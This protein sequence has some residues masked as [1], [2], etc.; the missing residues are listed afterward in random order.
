MIVFLGL[1]S[2][3][4]HVIWVDFRT[5]GKMVEGEEETLLGT[6]WTGQPRPQPK[7]KSLMLAREPKAQHSCV[8]RDEILMRLAKTVESV[9]LD[10][11][12][13]RTKYVQCKTLIR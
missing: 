10:P 5:K 3:I 4:Q 13:I 7:V 12:K 8:L 6:N 2:T 11:R 9:D 1:F